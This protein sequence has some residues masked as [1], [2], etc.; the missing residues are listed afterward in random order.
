MRSFNLDTID[1]SLLRAVP[2]ENRASTALVLPLSLFSTG[3]RCRSPEAVTGET[4][5]CLSRTRFLA[6]P[7]MM[8]EP[9]TVSVCLIFLS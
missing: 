2:V 1:P 3:N 6:C 9:S 7:C 5:C 8:F 4:W